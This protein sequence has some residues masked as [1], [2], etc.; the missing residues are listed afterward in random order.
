[1]ATPPTIFS[2]RSEDFHLSEYACLRKEIELVLKDYRALERNAV[3]AIGISW[4][5]LYDK[6]APAW[7]FCIP[8][9]FA[10]LGSIRAY[11]IAQTFGVLGRIPGQ[12]RKCIHDPR[13]PRRLG[14]LHTTTEDSL[15]EISWEENRVRNGRYTLLVNSDVS[16]C[17]RCL[18]AL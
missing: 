13:Q 14:A 9:L 16:N 12:D 15:V 10:I 1:M 7:V 18:P 11:G 4:G 3:V 5:W 8:C 17:D 6:K 2:Q